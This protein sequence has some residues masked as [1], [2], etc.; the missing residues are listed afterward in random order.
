MIVRTLGTP[1][2]LARRLEYALRPV[3]STGFL[4]VKVTPRSALHRGRPR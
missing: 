4:C 3:R 1:A 2:E